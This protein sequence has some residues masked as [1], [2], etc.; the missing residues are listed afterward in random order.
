MNH[1]LISF[2]VITFSIAFSGCNK[3]LS[4]SKGDA[5]TPVAAKQ[6]I[7]EIATSY[8][9]LTLM[10]PEPVFVNPELAMLCVGATKEMVDQARVDKG[11]HA[12]CSV[13]IFMNEIASTAFKNNDAY[14]VGAIIVK[15]KDVLGYRTKTDTKWQETGKGVG[16]MIKRESGFDQTNGNWEYFYFENPSSI[17]SGRMQSCIDCHVKARTS[18]FVFADWSKKENDTSY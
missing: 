14:P 12:N 7:A 8:S 10:T 11:P 9:D 6:D 5:Q 1:F 2:V 13:R 4:E 3:Q 15:E 18:D 16:G 17:E